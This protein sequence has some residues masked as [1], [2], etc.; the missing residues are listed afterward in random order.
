MIRNV[1]L[2]GES[3]GGWATTVSEAGSY[4]GTYP[5]P[6]LYSFDPATGEVKRLHTP[7]APTAASS[8]R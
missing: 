7:S 6:D 8:G 2:P 5:S 1:R 4:I 3:E